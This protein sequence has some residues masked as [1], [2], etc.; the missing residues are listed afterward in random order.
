MDENTTVVTEQEENV[1]EWLVVCRNRFKCSKCN[2][3]RNSDIQRGWNFCPFC[4]NRNVFK[5]TRYA[6]IE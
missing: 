6:H 5:D 4:G 3:G 2:K 1:G